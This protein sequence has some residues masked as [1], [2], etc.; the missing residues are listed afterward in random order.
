[1]F[2]RIVDAVADDVDDGEAGSLATA[3]QQHFHVLAPDMSIVWSK[4][5]AT[6]I[7]VC[8][9]NLGKSL[10]QELN[11]MDLCVSVKVLGE[12]ILVMCKTSKK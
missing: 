8:C 7:I 2:W 4:L 6:I 9:R 10:A 1:M 5:C 12:E 11:S 3:S